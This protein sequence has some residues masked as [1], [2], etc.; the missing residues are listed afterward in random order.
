[1]DMTGIVARHRALATLAAG[2]AAFAAG[3]GTVQQFDPAPEHLKTVE[4]A[5]DV[6]PA[7]TQLPAPPA[8]V[9]RRPQETYSVVV[10]DVPLK[11]V[12]F[13]LA[14][15]ARI[16]VDV[17]GDLQ[18][19]VTLNAVD[20]TLPQILD[21]L[22]RQASIRYTLQDGTLVVMPDAPYWQSYRVDYVNLARTT[23]GEVTVATQIATAGGSVDEESDSSASSD[24]ATNGSKTV[25]K[26]VADN[27]FW[28]MLGSNLRQLVTGR[29]QAGGGEAG[30]EGTEGADPVVVNPMTGMVSVQ[31]NSAQQAEVQAYLDQLTAGAKR[32]VLIEITVVEVDLNDQYQAGVDWSSVSSQGGLGKDGVSM[33]SDLL[34]GN[35]GAAPV[36]TTTYNN[37]DADGSGFSAT[38]KLLS[39]FG[40]TKVLSTPRIMALN[41]QTALLKVVE[42]YVYFSV[43]ADTTT[44]ANVGTTTA[45]T[46]TPQS[47]SVGLVV[48]VTPQI[49][50]AD[51][52]TLNVRPTITSVAR[53]VQDPNPDLK[54]ND[55]SNLVPVIRTREIES[56]MRVASGNIAILGGL[57]EDKIDYQTRRVPV[58]GQIPLAGELVNNRNNAAQKTEL[59]IFLRPVV[60]KDASLDGDYAGMRGFLPGDTFF[61]QPNEAQPFNVAPSR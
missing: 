45:Y 53:E 1:M 22:S 60:I 41:N 33:V 44:T 29:S 37:F 9:P 7:V 21:R 59:V 48:S 39:Q 3:C 58:L 16:N 42:N 36:F 27:S 38:V 13:A 56:I 14:R 54:K 55:I 12:L 47:V 52:V 6:P 4:G 51:A 23:E 24:S 40:N 25:V 17:T 2:L 19:N 11:D 57:M 34:G 32:Q 20:Q 5:R 8:P 35:L 18:G 28:A 26:N 15:D 10:T 43:K 46:T 61:A 30:A 50:D 31:A 49:S